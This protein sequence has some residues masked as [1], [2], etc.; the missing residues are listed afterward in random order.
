MKKGLIKYVFDKVKNPLAVAGI[1]GA[2]VM[3]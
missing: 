3:P 2:L 1:V